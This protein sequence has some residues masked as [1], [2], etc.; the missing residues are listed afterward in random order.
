VPEI[1]NEKPTKAQIKIII[2]YATQFNIKT[3]I[4]KTRTEARALAGELTDLGNFLFYVRNSHHEEILRK[5]IDTARERIG[6]LEQ[7]EEHDDWVG[8]A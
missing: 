2:K 5:I 3:V 8:L 7:E 1:A 4:P 6:C